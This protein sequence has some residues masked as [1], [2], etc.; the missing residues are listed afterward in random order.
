MVRQ[1]EKKKKKPYTMI[2]LYAEYL[3]NSK[4]LMRKT[5]SRFRR[6]RTLLNLLKI[7]YENL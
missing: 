7:I 4:I 3:K 2:S 1:T 5:L 6:E